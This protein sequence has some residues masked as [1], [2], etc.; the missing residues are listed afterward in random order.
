MH[1]IEPEELM[2]Y[3]DGELS[4]PRASEAAQHLAHCRECQTVAAEIQSVSRRLLEWQ[5]EEVPPG[6]ESAV[7]AATLPSR[8][9]LALW[10]G[11]TPWIV[12]LAAACAALM[13]MVVTP[14]MFH[15]STGARE[16]APLLQQGRVAQLTAP[17][18]RQGQQGQG[19]SAGGIG[20]LEVVPLQVDIAR[21]RIPLVI[22]TAQ[23]TLTTPDFA[24][25]RASLDDIL[26][27]HGGYLGNLTI[28]APADSGQTLQAT[29]RVPAPQL[30]A[31]LAEIRK[32]G[33]V[34]TEQQ[35]GEEVTQQMV[36]LEAR[37]SNARNTEQR[38]NDI[39]RRSAGKIAD[40]LAVEVQ[41]DRVRG[42]IERMEAERKNLGDR[43]NF[44][45]LEVRINEE[46]KAHL[47]VAAPSTFSRLRNAAVEGYRNVVDSLAA[48]G[49]F[50]LSY[51]PVV[52]FWAAVLF[53]PARYAWRRL[54]RRSI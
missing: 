50:L 23:I 5:V 10:T 35:G 9:R 32:L 48:L 1:P 15:E 25:T 47:A 19:G 42:E 51:G 49:M 17:P 40:V 20:P 12:G 18:A 16:V 7:S 27:R 13:L 41:I 26:K 45:T 53:F 11:R 46:Y 52:V 30:D 22:R 37:L 43:V 14:S 29:L 33:R 4:S 6:V 39:L 2:A 54:R 24:K 36:D 3:L 34:E 38:L 44:A 31:A 8:K 28:G 21:A